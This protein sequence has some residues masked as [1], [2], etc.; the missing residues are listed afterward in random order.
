[1]S[2]A[3][4]SATVSKEY[5]A[6]VHRTHYRLSRWILLAVLAI[7]LPLALAVA[8][9]SQA[10]GNTTFV[11][12]SLADDP[13]NVPGDGLCE[14]DLGECTLRAAI[15]EAQSAAYPGL[16]TIDLSSLTGVIALSGTVSAAA[17]PASRAAAG[18]SA[19]QGR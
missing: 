3:P 17:T 14:T 6:I 7:G 8:A 19:T 5:I 4:N 16:D 15:M 2:L 12:D 18:R 1:M 13:D 9:P 11:V 10:V